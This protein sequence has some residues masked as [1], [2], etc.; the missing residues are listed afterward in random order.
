MNGQVQ[1]IIAEG[2]RWTHRIPEAPAHRAPT[3]HYVFKKL[4]PGVGD[5]VTV[6]DPA[7]L[8]WRGIALL[9]LFNNGSLVQ[10]GTGFLCAPDVLL[11][12]RH[13]LANGHAYDALG[14]WFGM[15]ARNNPAPSPVPVRA[16]ALH[17]DLDLAILILATA[18]TGTFKLGAPA[19]PGPATL[20]IA[21]YA[22]PYSDG[23]VRLSYA[24]GAVNTVTAGTMAYAISTREGDS[25][26]PVFISTGA[27]A[28]AV[29]VHS[30]S[31]PDPIPAN[32]GV[33]LTPAALNDLAQ[34]IAWARTQT[35]GH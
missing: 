29:A 14:I 5:R 25:G 10:V 15:D 22:L 27:G 12:A 9:N 17:R 13:N 4:L 26:A 35:G 34:M 2:G 33:R 16:Y 23:G 18:Q 30:G 19:G 8:P 7:N 6:P 1:A 20:T 11:T 31:A 3:E 21:G 24:S 28:Q 32:T